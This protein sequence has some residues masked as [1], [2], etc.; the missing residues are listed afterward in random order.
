MAVPD[1]PAHPG[2]PATAARWRQESAYG[3][4]P[5]HRWA[6]LAE[7]HAAPRRADGVHLVRSAHGGPYELFTQG[8]PFEQQDGPVLVIFSGA[9][10]GRE[11]RQPPFLSG[12]SLAPGLGLP[13]VAVS[14]PALSL[15]ADLGIAWYAGSEH[16]QVQSATEDLLRPLAQRL[17]GELWL[18]GGSAGGFAALETGHRLGSSCSVFV[19]NPQTDLTEYFPRFVRHYGQAAFP[20]AAASLR[21]SQ[22]KARLAEAM[23]AAGCR[24]DLASGPP[25]GEAPRRLLY[26]Q[27]ADDDLHVRSHAAPYLESQGYRRLE[28]GLWT[29]GAQR[30]AWFAETGE[31]H[32][33]PSGDRI[34]A[35]LERLTRPSRETMLER[36]AQMDAEPFFDRSRPWTRPD[37]L[38]PVRDDVAG[39]VSWRVRGRRVSGSLRM[40]PP[41]YAR[42]RWR[43]DVLDG[44]DRVLQSAPDLPMPS[45]W[46]LAPEP[47]MRRVRVSLIDGMGHLLVRRHLTINASEVR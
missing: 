12:R 44:K 10:T 4:D 37:D 23:A 42:M 41:D 13:L 43:A 16:Q 17:R 24:S 31:G 30:V 2:Q 26:L 3:T 6:D 8:D 29:D 19:W 38:R 5:V 25:E 18:V 20:A 11:R 47:S 45:T 33:P 46:D 15:A 14:D 27:S 1:Q 7:F 35:I 21:G 40:L 22:W 39:L 32:T 9:V 36:V 34:H 28:P